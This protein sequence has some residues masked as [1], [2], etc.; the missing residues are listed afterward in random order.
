MQLLNHTFIQELSMLSIKSLLTWRLF[1]QLNQT[2]TSSFGLCTTFILTTVDND[3]SIS[4]SKYLLKNE[5][6]RPRSFN[7]D[8]NQSL[9]PLFQNLHF[10]LAI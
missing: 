8:E 4:C 6:E 2:S 3:V 10:S 9:Y 7:T 1:I 5:T